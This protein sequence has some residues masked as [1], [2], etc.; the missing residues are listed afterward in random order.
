MFRDWYQQPGRY[1]RPDVTLSDRLRI[2]QRFYAPDRP[3]GTVSSLAQEYALSRQSIYD[4]TQRVAVLF[5]PRKPD[6][7]PKPPKTP[8]VSGV[9]VFGSAMISANVLA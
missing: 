5:A 3:W 4:I 2:A 6:P 9:F 7:M 8:M 1:Q